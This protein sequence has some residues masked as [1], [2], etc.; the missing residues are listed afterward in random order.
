MNSKVLLIGYYGRWNF[1]D[2][3]MIL[4]LCEYLSKAGKIPM[5]VVAGEYLTSRLVEVGAKPIKQSPFKILKAFL[6]ANEIAMAGGTI[7]HD[8]YG[9]I[10]RVFYSL[11]L[12][13]FAFFL[14]AARLLGKR[15]LLI[16]VGIGP[17]NTPIA[18]G[19]ARL[20][21][22][23]CNASFVRD[24]ESMT[25]ALSLAPR[26]KDKIICGSDLAFLACSR[27]DELRKYIK[28]DQR[29]G[30]S[31]VD[32]RQFLSAENGKT[33][34]NNLVDSLSDQLERNPDLKVT[35]FAYWTAPNRPND[36]K[37][38]H[39]IYERFSNSAKPRID[40][41][42]YDGDLE[43]MLELTAQCDLMICTR[44]HSA[45]ISIIMEKPILLVNY[46]AKVKNLADDID[47]EPM[48]QFD[49]GA[50][51]DA[52][53]LN[54]ALMSRQGSPNVYPIERLERETRSALGRSWS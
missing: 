52:E 36:T 32:M 22:W 23:A 28:S 7:F 29:I 50:P 35:L 24:S 18:R 21:I 5:P 26:A 16:G 48:Y 19:A 20:A 45:I 33:F 12:W 11:K 6:S 17:L 51:I 8:S 39:N 49:G 42:A 1:G 25:C 10:G 43:L 9:G 53:K 37:L 3:I 13:V 41:H 31:V 4:S 46:N 14:L 47:L 40:I 38:L 27:I 54:H 30:V 34:W 2:D 15:S 44:F